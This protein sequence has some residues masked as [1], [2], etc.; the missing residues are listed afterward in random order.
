MEKIDLELVEAKA[1]ELGIIG[2]LL[3]DATGGRNEEKMRERQRKCIKELNELLQYKKGIEK[4]FKQYKNG[5]KGNE[6]ACNEG[7]V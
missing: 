7:K 4:Q 2:V 1:D 3:L 6:T 5:K